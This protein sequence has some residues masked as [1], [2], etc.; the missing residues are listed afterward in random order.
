MLQVANVLEKKE[1]VLLL[2]RIT[3]LNILTQTVGF[4]VAIIQ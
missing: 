3:I 4:Y 2:Q 1:T